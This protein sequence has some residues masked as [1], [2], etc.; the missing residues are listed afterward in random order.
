MWKRNLVQSILRLLKGKTHVTTKRPRSKKLDNLNV[1]F[2]QS[3]FRAGMKTRKHKKGFL[4][5]FSKKNG[6]VYSQL[7]SNV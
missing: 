3:L 2:L 4:N 1:R 6:G 7:K 5:F